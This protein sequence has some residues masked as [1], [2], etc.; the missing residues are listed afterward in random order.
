MGGKR[1]RGR[2][3]DRGEASG[4]ARGP[5]GQPCAP[6]ALGLGSARTSLEAVKYGRQLLSWTKVSS[7]LGPVRAS[8]GLQAMA[9]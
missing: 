1:G 3:E 8:P 6:A 9:S 2:A 5:R 7:K 4:G